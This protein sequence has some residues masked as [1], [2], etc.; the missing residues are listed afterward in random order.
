MVKLCYRDITSGRISLHVLVISCFGEY[1]ASVCVDSVSAWDNRNRSTGLTGLKEDL[2]VMNVIVVNGGV[3]TTQRITRLDKVQWP[4]RSQGLK[5]F[6]ENL[7]FCVVDI[8][9]SIITY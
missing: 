2:M 1:S 4:A 8:S 9:F 6:K 3:L 5:S 7:K